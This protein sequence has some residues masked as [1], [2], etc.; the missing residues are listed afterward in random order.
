MFSAH[1]IGLNMQAELDRL[2]AEIDS[3]T[4][5]DETQRVRVLLEQGTWLETGLDAVKHAARG[6]VER[7]RKVQKHSAGINQLMGE[8]RLST[9]EGVALM[10]LAEA[11]LRIPDSQ[12]RDEL[13]RDKLS[14][15][16]WAVHLGHSSSLFVNASTWGLFIAGHWVQMP[17][18]DSLY[19]SLQRLIA[20]S[21]EGLVRAAVELAV[22]FMGQQ[23]VA[24]QTIEEALR[25]SR[26]TAAQ[27]HTFSFDMLGEAAVCQA[28][29]QA[30][31][32][33]YAHAIDVIGQNNAKG[34]TEGHGI[35][36]KLS[37]LH[38]RYMLWQEKRVHAELYPRLYR[39]A[40][41]AK[42]YNMAFNVDAEE[43]ERLDLS[44]DLF[45]RLAYEPELKRWHG[46][47]LAVQAYQT[48]AT[49][50]V[51]FVA[52]L[53][54]AS[55]RVIQVR[56]VKGAYWDSEIKRCQIQG[57]AHFPVFTQKAHT[58]LSYLCCAEL[59]L[60]NSSYIYPQFAT[61]NAHTY[62]AVQHMATQLNVHSFEM[63]CL[64]GMGE[65]LYPQ[66]RIYAP[67]GTHQTLL[68]YLVRRLLE[69]G[70]NTS[71]V[72]QI[73]DPN[74]DL[75]DLVEHPVVTLRKRGIQAN[76]ACVPAPCL[77]GA[78]RLNSKGL[79][80]YCKRTVQQLQQAVD[81][82]PLSAS[83]PLPY[84][85][86]IHVHDA[87]TAVVQLQA[88]GCDWFAKGPEHRAFCLLQA[89][90]LLEAHQLQLIGLLVH[91]ARKTIPD[92]HMEVREA[93]DFC[94]Y[95]SAQVSTS[96]P[97]QLQST[98][99]LAVCISPWNFPLAIFMG[100]VVGALVSGHG[101][102]AKPAEQTPQIASYATRL[103]H[104]AGVPAA[105]LQ[106]VYGDGE[107]GSWLTRFPAVDTVLFTG[108]NA[109]AKHIQTS[110]LNRGNAQMPALLIAETGGQNAMVVDS[111]A[112]LEQ[113]V[114]DALESAFGSA[115]QRCSALRVLC[116]QDDIADRLLA[117]LKVAM[118]EL[119]VG[120][121][122]SFSTD[123]GPLIDQDAWQAVHA[124]IEGMKANGLPVFQA[125]RVDPSTQGHFIAP[126]LIELRQLNELQHEVFG[127]VLHVLRFN[128]NHLPAL[129]HELN[130]TGYALTFGIHSRIQ[131]TIDLACHTIEAGNVYVNRNMVGAVVGSQPFGGHGKSGTGPK[132]GGPHY[133]PTL[134]RLAQVTKLQCEILPGPTGEQNL[135]RCRPRGRVWCTALD[136]TLLRRQ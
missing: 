3:L 111:S 59:M 132:A 24:A 18:D 128:A 44:L 124:H 110:L 28:D 38:P 75:N 47:G 87:L 67:V 120:D 119:Q 68:P 133:V 69:N 54:R 25:N 81:S 32:N 22:K 77:F 65:G 89:A 109:A 20:R 78:Q 100:Q 115:G 8:Y 10:C 125:E 134:M 79:D 2:R 51:E 73:V 66:C 41:S 105:V 98:T 126:T 103:L 42:Q 131:S 37:A 50:V 13:I 7:L 23:F 14:H 92:A 56:L 46:L 102:V 43:S 39:L 129:L 86:Q 35:S 64:H 93:I 12:T 96:P 71:F 123:L 11:L 72:N 88:S 9:Q 117:L 107:V 76:P 101:V 62:A 61:H 84:S 15:A 58:D 94:R 33:S 17:G 108:S 5:V 85:T 97:Q 74:V 30:Y 112:L 6:H 70:A 4:R 99:R 57:L 53:A 31:F 135:Y 26:A 19:S 1:L 113:V 91:E 16:N 114:G 118:Q 21:S 90:E 122:A 40:L 29:A 83:T 27:G 34:V 106:L 136:E 45:T 104:E 95:Y 63:Q 36:V 55:E 116:V 127:P 130:A 60:R 52:A 121:P 49:A 82:S 48:R 80:L